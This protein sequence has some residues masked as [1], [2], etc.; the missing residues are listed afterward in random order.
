MAWEA[1]YSHTL[2]NN[3]HFPKL[4]GT[5]SINYSQVVQK[6]LYRTKSGWLHYTSDIQQSGKCTV[7]GNYACAIA[8]GGG[9]RASKTHQGCIITYRRWDFIWSIQSMG[10]AKL[11]WFGSIWENLQSLSLVLATNWWFIVNGKLKAALHWGIQWWRAFWQSVLMQYSYRNYGGW[12]SRDEK[13]N[14]FSAQTQNMEQEYSLLT[15]ASVT[16]YI[17]FSKETTW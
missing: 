2:S 17:Y 9:I 11:G 4:S 10:T 14:L 3:Y 1:L 8:G 13:K 5:I 6:Y 15:H 12:Y 16:P 7:K